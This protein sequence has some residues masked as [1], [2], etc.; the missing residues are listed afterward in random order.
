[1]IWNYLTKKIL[2]MSLTADECKKLTGGTNVNKRKEFQ[3][4]EPSAAI[5]HDI[6]ILKANNCACACACGDNGSGS[7][8][9]NNSGNDKVF[10]I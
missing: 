7:G 5:N 4:S 10:M 6:A 1:M 9:G 8:S 2:K 3:L